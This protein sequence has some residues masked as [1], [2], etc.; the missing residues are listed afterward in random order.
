MNALAMVL[1]LAVGPDAIEEAG[2]PRS[3]AA[4]PQ[5]F[6]ETR[7]PR[8][9]AEDYSV[10]PLAAE[11]ADLQ[12]SVGG[13]MGITVFTGGGSGAGFLIG[14]LG[15]VHILPWLGAEASLDII[16]P[17]SGG[18]LVPLEVS[19]LFYPPV[20]GAFHPYGQAGFGLSFAS[21]GGFSDVAAVFFLGFG[22]E[23]EL[24][25]NMMLDAN[26]RFTF[27]SAGFPD[28]FQLTV[29]ILF[30]LAK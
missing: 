5:I 30:K 25:P 16:I 27:E 6:E 20:E 28:I 17:F 13:R 2:L 11:K 3:L 18:T 14:G 9:L 21:F 12:W 7:L 24:Q 26:L 29:G 19:A 10:P 4:A 8:S 22:C 15:R 23:Y 1:A